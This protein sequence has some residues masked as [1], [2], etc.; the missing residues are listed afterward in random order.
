M[1]YEIIVGMKATLMHLL[2][3]RSITILYPHEKKALLDNYLSMLGVFRYDH[4][5][6]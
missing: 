1:L 2:R 3:F 4:G 6:D 5:K